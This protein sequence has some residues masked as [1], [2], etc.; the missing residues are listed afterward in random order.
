MDK[1]ILRKVPIKVLLAI[2][3][4][5]VGGGESH[6]LELVQGFRKTHVTPVVLSFTPGE[7]IERLQEL[8][9]ETHVI[10]TTTPFDIRVWP[11]VKKLLKSIEPDIVHAHGTRAASNTF[12][13]AK[14]LDLPLLYTVHGWSFHQ[15]QGKMVYNARLYMEQFLTSQANLNICVSENNQ[16]EGKEL[17]GLKKSMVIHN[18]VN[19]A[20]FNPDSTWR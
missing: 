8:G 4:G 1:S 5:Q 16:R 20:K 2:R 6:V 13:P 9:A 14:Q 19:L 12:W 15:G 17:F 11:K 3:Q 18:G 7:M 10:E